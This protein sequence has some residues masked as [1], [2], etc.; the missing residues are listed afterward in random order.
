MSTEIEIGEIQEF[1]PELEEEPKPQA[2]PEIKVRIGVGLKIAI[3]IK[4]E[5]TYHSIAPSRGIE[6]AKDAYA[7]TAVLRPGYYVAQISADDLS[8]D[9]A[10][11]GPRLTRAQALSAVGGDPWEDYEFLEEE[12]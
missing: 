4:E 11:I 5:G 8:L 9:Q 10:L 12:Q 6:V 1:E 7:S 2:R 3:E